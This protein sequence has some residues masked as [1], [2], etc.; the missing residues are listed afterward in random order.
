MR[1]VLPFPPPARRSAQRP[2]KLSGLYPPFQFFNFDRFQFFH[3][4]RCFNF[5]IFFWIWDFDF[6]N[7][8]RLAKV[9]FV[10][11]LIFLET[12]VSTSTSGFF[13]GFGEARQFCAGFSG[14]ARQTQAGFWGARCAG[15]HGQHERPAVGCFRSVFVYGYASKDG[16]HRRFSATGVW[17]EGAC[18]RSLCSLLCVH[19][20]ARSLCPI[21]SLAVS[22]PRL[23][24]LFSLACVLS[25]S[26]YLSNL[27]VFVWLNSNLMTNFIPNPQMGMEIHFD[28]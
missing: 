5:N 26:L 14:S 25:L 1:I 11:Q 7:L 17:G 12:K 18:L 28:V 19:C 2:K 9:R 10:F 8:R 6:S 23:S 20:G 16:A 27:S 3:F 22:L 4:N 13:P 21:G 15:R 24:L